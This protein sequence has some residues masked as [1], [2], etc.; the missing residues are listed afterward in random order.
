MFASTEKSPLKPVMFCQKSDAHP[1][2]NKSIKKNN[3]TREKF[4]QRATTLTA[5]LQYTIFRTSHLNRVENDHRHLFLIYEKVYS[6]H[7]LVFFY[8]LCG[9]KRSSEIGIGTAAIMESL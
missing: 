5:A 9:I 3:V 8:K 4:I 1:K 6:L 2:C 7:T